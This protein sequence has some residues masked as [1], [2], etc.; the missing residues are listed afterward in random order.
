MR[1][2]RY[3]TAI[4]EYNYQSAPKSI[5]YEIVD[6]LRLRQRSYT[7]YCYGSPHGHCGWYSVK[8][9]EVFRYVKSTCIILIVKSIAEYRDGSPQTDIAVDIPWRLAVLWSWSQLLNIDTVARKRTL[10]LI[11]REDYRS[12]PNREVI[13]QYSGAWSQLQHSDTV[14]RK[15]IL[16][17]IFRDP[18]VDLKH[19]R[20]EVQSNIQVSV[21][22]TGENCLAPKKPDKR[23]VNW[24][25]E[26]NREV[27]EQ[28][29]E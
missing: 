19:T 26:V 25:F 24:I 2:H 21:D 29:S 7:E 22:S 4:Q 5:Q 23:E 13:L 1:I 16:R 15:L 3:S 11:F 12:V 20:N 6:S 17:L 18:S 9:V 10:R 27:A 28:V 8:T 14:A